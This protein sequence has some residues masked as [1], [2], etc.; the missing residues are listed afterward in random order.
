[1]PPEKD[2]STMPRRGNG[3]EVIRGNLTV[4]GKRTEVQDLIVNGTIDGEGGTGSPVDAQYVVLGAN[5]TLTDERVLTAGAG[6]EITD[7]GAGAAVTIA[8][9][10]SGG[11][12]ADAQYMVL[13]THVDLSAE[14]A[15]VA[16]DGISV[17]DGG[18]GGNVTLAVE[19]PLTLG[20]LYAKGNP[21]HD[22]K[23]YGAVGDGVA[24]DTAAIQAAID[25]LGAS[26]GTVFLPSGDYK[27]T[28]SLVPV[29]NLFFLGAGYTATGAAPTPATR[30]KASTLEAPI[31]NS[32]DKS[33]VHIR[34]IAFSGK[35]AAGSKGI[36]ATGTYE[37]TIEDCF[38]DTFG[39]SAIEI[40]SGTGGTFGHI[41]VQNTL[42]VRT[43][44]GA[45]IGCVDIGCTDA[46]VWAITSTASADAIGDGYIAGIVLR[47][48]NGFMTNC[49]GHISQVGI[50]IPL[51][52]AICRMIGCRA[53]LNY[54][55]GFVVG[56]S[57]SEFIGNL[58][59]RNSR[60]GDDLHS[61]F[62]VTNGQNTFV[63]N[64]ITGL[65]DDTVQQHDGFDDSASVGAGATLGNSYYGN[66]ASII[67]GALYDI[68]GVSEHGTADLIGR[69]FVIGE[70][71]LKIGTSQVVGNRVVDARCDDAINSGDATTDGVIDA[72]RDAMIAHGLIAA[73]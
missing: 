65:S 62:L 16:G 42:L 48:T 73:A 44:R 56:G 64:R 22:V 72:L 46:Y 9:T 15:L 50:V 19:D 35:N 36:Y 49:T 13:A 61:G 18:A 6:I 67:R 1:M 12:P 51:A 33:S 37:W 2:D 5:V 47:G 21:W 39:D 27:I 59:W 45:Y 24:D 17:T 52:T 29:S 4:L 57:T 7:G 43:G 14:R 40:A 41:F 31:I 25:A 26:G 58:A 32:A 54:G 28:A 53:D 71:I 3:D 55:P 66:R 34:G 38:F 8:A 63:G 11:C 30:L 20:A 60:A 70:G 69:D 10:G 68:T 23:A